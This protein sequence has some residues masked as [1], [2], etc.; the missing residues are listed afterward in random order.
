VIL[1]VVAGTFNL[2]LEISSWIDAVVMAESQAIDYLNC[3]PAGGAI[4]QVYGLMNIMFALGF[5]A[6]PLGAGFIY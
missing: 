2:F 4:A 5:V 1:L 6:G 3:F